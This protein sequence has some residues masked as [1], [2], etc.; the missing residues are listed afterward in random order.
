MTVLFKPRLIWNL[1]DSD[2]SLLIKPL[3]ESDHEC[4]DI[5]S[6]DVSIRV[7]TKYVHPLP[8]T[9]G[10][11]ID[12]RGH[13]LYA[14]EAAEASLPENN[15]FMFERFMQLDPDDFQWIETQMTPF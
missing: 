2:L 9:R 14:P 5:S 3:G 15:D 12:N 8:E 4:A 13:V 10:D 7:T 1:L 6:M 11:K